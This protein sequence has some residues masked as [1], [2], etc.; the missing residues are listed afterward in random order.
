MQSY[1]KLSND[2]FV[3]WN[4]AIVVII[5][6]MSVTGSAAAADCYC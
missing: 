1:L 6:D 5:D 4:N 3:M 2:K